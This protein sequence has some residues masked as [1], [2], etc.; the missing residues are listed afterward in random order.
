MWEGSWFNV[1]V[2]ANKL[3]LENL[4]DTDPI[5]IAKGNSYAAKAGSSKKVAY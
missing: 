2:T 5:F 4:S 3:E 1:S